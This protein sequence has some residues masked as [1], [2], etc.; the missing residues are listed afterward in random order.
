MKKWFGLLT[1][2]SGLFLVACGAKQ[3]QEAA[4]PASWADRYASLVASG[5]EAKGEEFADLQKEVTAIR[6]ELGDAY[7]YI[8]SPLKAGKAALDGDGSGDFMLTVDGSDPA[9]DWGVTYD[10]EAQFAEGWEGQVSVARSAWED[11]DKE[12]WSVFA[13]VTDKDGKVVALL[14]IDTDVTDLMKDFPEWN[15]DK[16]DWNGYTHDVPD[17]F[18]VPIQE[19]LDELKPLVEEYAKTLSYTEN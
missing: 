19:K 12:R 2:L 3:A 7:V 9:E 4:A 11:G 6:K 15:R 17:G 13:P 5:K 10:A 18:P 16:E 1:L 8:I 14:G